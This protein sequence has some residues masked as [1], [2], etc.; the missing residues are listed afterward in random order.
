MH[1][2]PTLSD[3]SPLCVARRG[4]SAARLSG[5]VTALCLLAAIYPASIRAQSSGTMQ[6]TA[7]VVPADPAWAGLSAA[8][9]MARDLGG[10]TAGDSR[11]VDLPLATVK[12]EPRGEA[13]AGDAARPTISIQYLRN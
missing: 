13:A 3:R 6:V 9:G 12:L 5:T 7:V 8:Q 4:A 11:R 1:R 10:D 2:S